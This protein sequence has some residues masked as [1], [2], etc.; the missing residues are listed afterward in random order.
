VNGVRVM[1]QMMTLTPQ[2]LNAV[3]CSLGLIRVII[4]KHDEDGNG[5]RLIQVIMISEMK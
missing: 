4:V 5:T 2:K 3:F 1:L